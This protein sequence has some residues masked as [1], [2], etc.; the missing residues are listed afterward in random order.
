MPSFVVT[1]AGLLGWNGVVLLLIGDRGTVII[2]STF[3]V[4]FANDFL[5]ETTSWILAFVVI[6][7]Y[8][9]VLFFQRTQRRRAGLDTVPDVTTYS[10]RLACVLAG[11]Y[12]SSRSLGSPTFG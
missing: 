9:G 12:C 11:R 10:P 3:L 6:G 4:G 5:P 2:Q 8:A 1:L 7:I